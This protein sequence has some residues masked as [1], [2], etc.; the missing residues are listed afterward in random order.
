MKGLKNN[1]LACVYEWFCKGINPKLG[2]TETKT[3]AGLIF[4]HFHHLSAIDLMVKKEI[5][6]SESEIVNLY[7]VM[8]LLVKEVPVQH[9]TGKSYFR[10]LVLKVTGEV[11]IP[12]PETEELVEWIL[13]DIRKDK[14]I[15]P[16]SV[17]DIGTG[18]GAI[19][20]SLA[21]ELKGSEVH[22]SD[23]SEKALN[24]ARLNASCYQL[25][26][27]F[28]NHDILTEKLPVNQFDVIVSNP[29]YIRDQE[30]INMQNN[31]LN[32]EPHSALFVPDEDPLVFY[33]AIA[34]AAV[35]CL[36]PGGNLY[37]EINESLGSQT[38]ALFKSM[39]L[40]GVVL[41]TDL[42][43]K[44]RFVKGCKAS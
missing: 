14:I 30:K 18:S 25:D 43:G 28:F 12:R 1:T 27:Q 17:W 31:V 4:E 7:R 9:I 21:H 33:H 15:T 2:A 3:I 35:G 20:L 24:I 22:A 13:N 8:E 42:S 40:T 16:I 34:Q 10:E 19:A 6:L 37:V 41:K 32:Y 44:D 23:I 38:A 36:K 26:V 39:G 11:L 29:P 5:R